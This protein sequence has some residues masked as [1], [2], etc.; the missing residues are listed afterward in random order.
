MNNQTR[1]AG[2]TQKSF[3]NFGKNIGFGERLAQLPNKRKQT[4]TRVIE[5]NLPPGGTRAQPRRLHLAPRHSRNHLVKRQSAPETAGPFGCACNPK[6]EDGW[7][8]LIN[9]QPR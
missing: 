8:T 4:A 3:P 9:E 2:S 5:K 7:T 6:E 1:E